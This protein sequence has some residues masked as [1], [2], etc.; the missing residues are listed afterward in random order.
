MGI[1]AIAA[2]NPDSLPFHTAM[3]DDGPHELSTA[4]GFEFGAN[5]LFF[6]TRRPRQFQIRKNV[7]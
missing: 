5:W 4:Y 1:I 7:G 2:H 6:S 3:Q